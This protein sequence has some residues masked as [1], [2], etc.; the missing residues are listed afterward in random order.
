MH[1]LTRTPHSG[2]V[3]IRYYHRARD[4]FLSSSM[5]N[6]YENILLSATPVSYIYIAIVNYRSYIY[7]YSYIA[8]TI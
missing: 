1:E 6:T 7:S 8:T 2:R 5:A 4:T 3:F